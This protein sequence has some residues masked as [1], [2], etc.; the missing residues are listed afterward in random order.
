M[1]DSKQKIKA[2]REKVLNFM[3]SFVKALSHSGYYSADH[4]MAHN[5]FQGLYTHFLDLIGDRPEMSFFRIE[6]DNSR[7]IMLDGLFDESVRMSKMMTEQAGELFIPKLHQYFIRKKILSFTL[8]HEIAENEF[9]SF[10]TLLSEAPDV[11]TRIQQQEREV[12]N[13]KLVEAGVLHVSLLFEEDIIG[14]ERKLPW[15]VEMALTRLRRDLRYLPLYRNL[16]EEQLHQAKGKVFQDIIRPLRQPVILKD[17]LINSD[18]LMVESEYLENQSLESLIIEHI[19]ETMIPEIVKHTLKDWDI[20]EQ[21]QS[22]TES[23]SNQVMIDR[24]RDV[25]KKLAVFFKGK[26]DPQHF[27]TLRI[28]LNKKVISLKELPEQLTREIMIND[29]IGKF[30]QNPSQFFLAARNA[31]DF[32]HYSAAINRLVQIFPTLINMKQ[33]H[34]AYKILTF[35]KEELLSLSDPQSQKGKFVQQNLI[36]IAH[37]ENSF[38][39][40]KQFFLEAEREERDQILMIFKE[41][42]KTTLPLLFDI[43]RESDK[44]SVRRQVIDTLVSYKTIAIPYVKTLLEDTSQ[45]WFVTRNAIVIASEIGE[46]GFLPIILRFKNHDQG[47]I[48]EEVLSALAKMQG[49]SALEYL[50]EAL[51]DKELSVKLKAIDV[52]SSMKIVDPTIL[53]YYGKYLQYPASKEE[54]EHETIQ[55]HILR[56]LENIDLN[57][58]WSEN[59][60]FKQLLHSII[61]EADSSSSLKKLLLKKSVRSSKVIAAARMVLQKH[62]SLPKNDER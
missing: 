7:D 18:L 48:R 35:L 62:A 37:D 24:I 14:R 19:P 36:N 39:Q 6:E 26:N 11:E 60:T 15:R 46:P 12:F 10:V 53:N 51:N 44:I 20:F 59:E 5:A 40:L 9:I 25:A 16:S 17:F 47:Q 13:M 31:P 41:F 58:N 49:P 3:L 61:A 33:L 42:K 32:S 28:L 23:E 38:I 52:L 1:D 30:S 50:I 8:K 43:L 27:D 2:S 29:W 21:K 45:P 34:P 55:L 56:S 57:Q 54:V 4:P 22:M